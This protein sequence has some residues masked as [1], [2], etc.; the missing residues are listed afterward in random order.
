MGVA[1]INYRVREC[2]MWKCMTV[3]VEVYDRKYVELRCNNGHEA[4]R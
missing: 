2:G 1:V 4:M 3:N